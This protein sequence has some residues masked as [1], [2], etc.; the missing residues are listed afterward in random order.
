[1][2]LGRTDIENPQEIRFFSENSLQVWP[3]ACVA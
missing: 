1:M 3:E 2:I